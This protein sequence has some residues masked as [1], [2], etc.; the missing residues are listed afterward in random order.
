MIQKVLQVGNSL[1]VTIPAD[2]ARE[3]KL[4]PGKKLR[5]EED[6]E[7]ET[8]IVQPLRPTLPRG[9]ITPEFVSWLKRF[10]ARYKDALRELA[11][12]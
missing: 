11:K 7:G 10:N 3:L 12:K 2:F 9:G 1:A 6:V 4:Q 8:L 5:V